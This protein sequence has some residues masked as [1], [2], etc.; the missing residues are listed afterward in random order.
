MK[1]TTRKGL[2]WLLTAAL[3]LMLLVLLLPSAL[4]AEPVE[5]GSFETLQNAVAAAPLGGEAY[6]VTVTGDIAVNGK[7]TVK[8]GQNITIKSAGETIYTLSRDPN[9]TTDYLIAVESGASLNLENLTFDGG[10]PNF[11]PDIENADAVG[12]GY[13]KID[14]LN[15]ENDLQARTALLLNNGMLTASHVTFQ[16]SYNAE[17]NSK[18]GAVNVTG[19]SV[20]MDSCVFDHNSSV[21]G[22]GVCMIGSRDASGNYTIPEAVFQNCKFQNGFSHGVGYGGAIYAQTVK[23]ITLETCDFYENTVSFYNG[24]AIDAEFSGSYTDNDM[25]LSATGCNFVGN[26]V[27]N[28]GFALQVSCSTTIKDCNFIKNTGLAPSQSIGTISYGPSRAILFAKH[29]LENCLFDGNK[30]AAPC[31][32][33]HA[34][35]QTIQVRRCKFQNNESFKD[36]NG[37][38]LLWCSDTVFESCTFVNNKCIVFQLPACIDSTIIAEVKPRLTV[39]NSTISGNEGYSVLYC[40]RASIDEYDAFYE[41]FILDSVVTGNTCRGSAFTLRDDSVASI[42]KNTQI[43]KNTSY[44]IIDLDRRASAL[45]DNTRITNNTGYRAVYLGKDAS[46]SLTNSEFLENKIEGNMFTLYGTARVE[47]T[48]IQDNES[49]LVIIGLYESSSASLNHTSILQNEAKGTVAVKKAVLTMGGGSV[50]SGN[51][52]VEYGGGIA[53]FSDARVTVDQSCQI[54]NN[55]CDAQADDIY[56]KGTG[57]EVKLPD[58]GSQNLTLDPCGDAIDGWYLDHTDARYHAH[59]ISDDDTLYIEAYDGIQSD[60]G[61][62]LITGVDPL[63]LKAAHTRLYTITYLVDGEIV[64][65]LGSAAAAGSLQTV[66]DRFAKT[67]YFVSDWQSEDVD[68]QNGRFVMPEKDV[69]ITATSYPAVG[70]VSGASNDVP[71]L[72]KDDHVAYIIGYEDG[73][74][75]PNNSITRAEVATIF[76][77]LLTDDTRAH[78]WSQTN[79]YSDVHSGD[80]FNNAVSTM[81][82]AGIITGYPDGTFRPN[83][84]ITRA[85]FAAIVARF[86]D[87][88]AKYLGTFSDVSY[89]HWA[90]SSIALAAK[91]GWVTGYEDNTFK[92][93]QSIT[94]AEAMTITNRILERAVE[95]DHMLPDMVTWT[96]NRPDAWY[97]EAVQEATNSHTYARVAKL[98]PDQSYCYEEWLKIEANPD[99]AALEKIWSRANSR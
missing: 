74:V 80:W 32:G 27:G 2:R 43:T 20:S 95:E 78:Y 59:P 92:P 31:F 56:I 30:G 13:Y 81:S 66:A 39:Q 58:V 68:I 19:G 11:G 34:D 86:N 69:V 61:T 79:S 93:D 70:S 84:P 24:G 88:S 52:A 90:S 54:Y 75:R 41:V 63:Y 15:V 53:M 23:M 18:G 73:T 72:N 76:F 33:D 45:L 50:I 25:S 12:G 65:E 26:T 85:E 87:Q 6:A 60:D 49:N 98:V 46:I 71:L 3:T 94:R 7:L 21:F 91:F 42:N 83:A 4:A 37:A 44:N 89:T 36:T 57:I 96:D 14:V 9:Y 48:I 38:F 35:F 47:N 1:E 67:G 40:Y 97:Y 55:R 29:V 17:N 62:Y 10:A 22:A 51:H 64:S 5:V 82:A 77:R 8:S 99:W 16:N 28:D